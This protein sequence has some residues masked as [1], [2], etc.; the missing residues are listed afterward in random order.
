V[1]LPQDATVDTLLER[2]GVAEPTIAPALASAL[3]VVR[4]THVS[5]EQALADGDEVALL[6]AVAGGATGATPPERRIPWP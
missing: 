3:A 5:G 2:L 4:G 1:E 6:I